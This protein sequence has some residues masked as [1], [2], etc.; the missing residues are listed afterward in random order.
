MKKYVLYNSDNN[1]D[2]EDAANALYVAY[3]NISLVNLKSI[4]DYAKFFEKL[5]ADDEVI[6]CGN[7]SIL[8]QFVNRTHEIPM[9]NELYFFSVGRNNDFVRNLG[10]EPEEDPVFSINLSVQNLPY[11]QSEHSKKIFVSNVFALLESKKSYIKH[12]ERKNLKLKLDDISYE[13]NDVCAVLVLSGQFFH[14]EKIASLEEFSHQKQSVSVIIFQRIGKYK[15][16]KLKKDIR[17]GCAI[18]F[19][20]KK[21]VILQGKQ[22]MIHSKTPMSLFVDGDKTTECCEFAVE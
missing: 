11:V 16:E 20:R 12:D 19:N 7:D 8:S 10:Y 9:K 18:H 2:F 1:G 4:N 5:S 21:T 6:L 15:A 13:Y 17:D 14:S 3:D 22:L